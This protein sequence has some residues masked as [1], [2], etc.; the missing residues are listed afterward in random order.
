MKIWYIQRYFRTIRARF[1]QNYTNYFVL[2]TI[3]HKWCHIFPALLCRNLQNRCVGTTS[4]AKLMESVYMWCYQKSWSKRWTQNILPEKKDH[5]ISIMCY[6]TI[7]EETNPRDKG[8]R[9]FI[10][11]DPYIPTWLSILQTISA[12]RVDLITDKSL[13]LYENYF[14]FWLADVFWQNFRLSVVILAEI[15]MK[16]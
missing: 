8:F 6:R 12:E 10:E 2:T 4:S 3:W 15:Q 9:R 7:C 5:L 1:V 14:V 13:H 11:M 16:K